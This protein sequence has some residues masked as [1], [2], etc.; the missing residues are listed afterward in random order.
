MTLVASQ[1]SS[2]AT[3]GLQ[4]VEFHHS[5][6]S[7]IREHTRRLHSI[8]HE[9]GS[10]GLLDSKLL[11]ILLLLRGKGKDTSAQPS[12]SA[13]V[14]RERRNRRGEG[15]KMRGERGNREGREV[16]RER[17]QGGEG[18]GERGEGEE[19]DRMEK[20]EEKRSATSHLTFELRH[21]VSC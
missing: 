16:G 10:D 3:V 15:R 2:C 7:L 14:R 1:S 9:L 4:Q 17:E 11:L 8:Q 12:G 19:R 21:A 18:G 20:E 13:C 6:V 5:H